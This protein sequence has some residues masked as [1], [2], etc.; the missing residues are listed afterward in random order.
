MTIAY[1]DRY[2]HTGDD[3]IGPEPS[4]RDPARWGTWHHAQLVLG[5]A[6]VTGQLQTATATQLAAHVAGQRAADDAAPPYVADRLRAA[7][8]DLCTGETRAPEITAAA[9]QV[10]IR[11]HEL[12]A[13]HA[14]WMDWYDSTLTVR[15]T[16]HAARA[17]QQRRLAAAHASQQMARQMLKDV[18]TA[19]AK[20]RAIQ[21]T[22]PRIRP[23]ASTRAEE[24]I[25]EATRPELSE[26]EVDL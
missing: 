23:A 7:Y 18:Q 20:V 1:R 14:F 4:R 26:A 3:P 13:A 25:A 11:V 2:H 8:V 16:G 10:W 24:D 19:T 12:E 21:A 17:E 5:T 6:T 22:A 9:A 15:Y